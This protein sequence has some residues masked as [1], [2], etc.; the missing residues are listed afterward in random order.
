[1]DKKKIAGND[2]INEMIYLCFDYIRED[3]KNI[4]LQ[5]FAQQ[6]N[7]SDQIMHTLR[8]LVLGAFISSMG[9][10]V[11]YDFNFLGKTPDWCIFDKDSNIKGVVELTNIHIDKTTE[12][13]I[14]IHFKN[15]S[16]VTYWRDG[17]KDNIKRLY[18]NILE[19]AQVYKQLVTTNSL[20]Y[21]IAI[22]IEFFIPIDYEEELKPCL[23][24]CETGL[25]KLY[26][27]LSSVVAFE[28]KKGSYIFNQ[29]VNP[30]ALYSLKLSEGV[31][32]KTKA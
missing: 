19:K 20:P 10:K 23:F 9:Y 16:L 1:M 24:D 28:E 6:P 26:P 14:K 15:N 13:K 30:N 12:N 11:K 18:Q 32:P 3:D 4:F 29:F 27:E 2:S 25:F 22:F 17:N 8:E 5:K 31:F 7:N 21:I